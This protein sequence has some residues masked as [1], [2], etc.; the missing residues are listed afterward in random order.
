MFSH[1]WFSI[2]FHLSQFVTLPE[3]ISESKFLSFTI[4]QS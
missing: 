2:I 4:S 3:L 1:F